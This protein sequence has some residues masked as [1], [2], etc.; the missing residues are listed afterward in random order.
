MGSTRSPPSTRASRPVR[1]RLSEARAEVMKLE[2]SNQGLEF[3]T[4]GGEQYTVEVRSPDGV[5]KCDQP[6]RAGR[7]CRLYVPPGKATV[8]V[9][10]AT[11]MTKELSVP[12]G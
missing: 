2:R 4:E 12:K 5:A 11:S 6:V 3:A 9:G 8:T 7:N 10:G 1:G